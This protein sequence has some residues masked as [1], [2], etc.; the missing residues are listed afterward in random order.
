MSEESATSTINP[1]RV[2]ISEPEA[3]EKASNKGKTP[4]AIAFACVAGNTKSLHPQVAKIITTYSDKYIN[5]Y[6]KL[7]QKQQQYN[8]MSQDVDFIPRSAR[9][10]FE[11]YVRPEI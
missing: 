9:I 10:N 2:R 11:F 3:T 1:K 8:R 6:A 4:K 7:T 5:T